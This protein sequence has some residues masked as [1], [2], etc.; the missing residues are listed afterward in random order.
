[1]AV[2]DTANTW[3]VN[4]DQRKTSSN[5]VRVKFN[6]YK[7]L[8]SKASRL[9]KEKAIEVKSTSFRTKLLTEASISASQYLV[10]D[11][12]S[13]EVLSRV[14]AREKPFTLYRKVRKSEGKLFFVKNHFSIKEDD[15][16]FRETLKFYIERFGPKSI[17]TRID[18]SFNAFKKPKNNQEVDSTQQEAEYLNK[19]AQLFE[20]SKQQLIEKYSGKYILFEDGK[21][22]DVGESRAEV[23][24]RAYEQDGMRPLFIK[25]VI[26][27]AA[28]KRRAIRTPFP[29]RLN[30]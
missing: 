10:R 5:A 11:L 1:M 21:V 4:S 22:L 29:R 13:P 12:K 6:N 18:E 25:Q 3:V 2:L 28:L 14:V 17:E 23:A 26:S 24:M 30:K 15:I 19:Q 20:A 7:T 8:H 16:A 27:G 9:D